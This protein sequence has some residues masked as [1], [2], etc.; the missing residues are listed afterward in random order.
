M[1]SGAVCPTGWDCIMHSASDSFRFFNDGEHPGAGG[2][3]GC[4][5]SVG[6][7]PWG[8]LVQG[9]VNIESLRGKRIRLR[10]L[11]RLENVVGQG[12]GPFLLAQGGSGNTLANGFEPQAGTSGWHPVSAELDVPQGTYLLELGFALVGR[13]R[14]CVDDVRFEVL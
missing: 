8:K 12:A 2:R 11:A 4:F 14:L 3:S 7:Q 5:E 1:R 13:G 9:H 6:R 10:A